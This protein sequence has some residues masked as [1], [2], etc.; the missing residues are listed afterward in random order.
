MVGR[1]QKG[2]QC[3]VTGAE[4]CKDEVHGQATVEGFLNGMNTKAHRWGDTTPALSQ[5]L[6][7]TNATD[8]MKIE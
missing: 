5:S 4:A 7:E 3:E 8:A 2:V 6:L 1:N